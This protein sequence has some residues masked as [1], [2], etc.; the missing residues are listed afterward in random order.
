M[1]YFGSMNKIALRFALVL[2]VLFGSKAAIASN[3]DV[4][5]HFGDLVLES[6]RSEHDRARYVKMIRDKGY[7]VVRVT[8][9]AVDRQFKFPSEQ[10]VILISTHSNGFIFDNYIALS[11]GSGCEVLQSGDGGCLHLEYHKNRDISYLGGILNHG[12]AAI[13]KQIRTMPKCSITEEK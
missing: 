13:R 2:V 5:V 10:K 11:L 1:C 7:D 3:C 12:R 6:K 8:D 4:A 9:G